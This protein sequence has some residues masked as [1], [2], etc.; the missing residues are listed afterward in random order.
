MK[1]LNEKKIEKLEKDGKLLTIKTSLCLGWYPSKL[2][3]NGKSKSFVGIIDDKVLVIPNHLMTS[4]V[5]GTQKADE[6]TFVEQSG[7]KV[8]GIDGIE[9]SQYR[10]LEMTDDVAVATKGLDL[11]IIAGKMAQLEL[12]SKSS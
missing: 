11:A 2:D 7:D 3:A 9:R 8:A 6:I 10:M 4:I 1:H 12:I 5:N